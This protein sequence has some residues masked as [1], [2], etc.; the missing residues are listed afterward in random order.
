MLVSRPKTNWSHRESVLKVL[1]RQLSQ[2]GRR[3][4]R[5][6][7]KD[8]Y[9]AGFSALNCGAKQLLAFESLRY[10]INTFRDNPAPGLSPLAWGGYNSNSFAGTFLYYTGFSPG[11]PNTIAIRA[12]LAGYILYGWADLLPW[13]PYN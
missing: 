13:N 7:G 1:A 6:N 4:L 9:D 5:R 11:L 10:P 2:T 8:I 3:N 12:L